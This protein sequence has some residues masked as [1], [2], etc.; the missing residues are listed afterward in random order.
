[1]ARIADRDSAAMLELRDRLGGVILDRVCGVTGD[2]FVAGLVTSGVLM[3]VWRRPGD[4]SGADLRLALLSL[5]EQRAHQW[6][7]TTADPT[8][9]TLTALTWPGDLATD[10]DLPAESKAA[11]QWTAM[12]GRPPAGAT[13]RNRE[14]T[15]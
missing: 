8:A 1:V 9:T 2:R 4:F 10:A 7:A 11:P 15:G 5:A 12:S 14:G 3:R 13:K 6:L